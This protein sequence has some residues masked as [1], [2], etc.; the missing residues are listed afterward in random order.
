MNRFLATPHAFITLLTGLFFCLGNIGLAAPIV[1][2]PS[3]PTQGNS[4]L[5]LQEMWRIGGED[6]EDNLL[7]VIGKVLAD[8]QDQVY[9]LDYQLTEVMVYN[10]EGE[11]LKSLGS[12][13]EG[14]GEIRRAAGV[15]FMPDNTIGLVQGFPG[16]IVLVDHQG[17][18]AGTYL[19]GGSDPSAGGFF[20]LRAAASRNGRLVFSGA[21]I[22][23]GDN[24]RTAVHFVASFADDGQ[25]INLYHEM[26]SVRQFHG[27]EFS[28]K[29]EFFPHEDGWTLGPEG[30]VFV[31]Q[32]RNDYA[33]TVY[34]PSGTLERT[35]KRPYKSWNRT[36]QEKKIAEDNLVPWRRRNRNRLDF[37]VEPT[38]P[39][40]AQLRVTDDGHLWVLP[41]RGLREQP[42]GVHSTWDVFDTSGRWEQS[43]SIECEGVGIRD[44]LFFAGDD[45]V[46]LVKQ[47]ADALKA[48]RGLSTE[49]EESDSE[50]DDALPLEV[51]CYRINP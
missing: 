31:C 4:S 43:V 20:A 44:R 32:D 45:L 22:S 8:D 50:E 42:A 39:D 2:N 49:D 35:I 9:L 27:Q 34:T 14:P 5:Q 29:K 30:R 12:Q 25:E 17:T 10:A 7:G 51:I 11:Y 16:K 21:R 15:L 26:T 1:E 38:E 33:I 40:I 18:P 47:Y 13:G 6:D 36:S 28:E 37:V 41:S 19:P 48:F 46:I 3:T 24:S 23:R